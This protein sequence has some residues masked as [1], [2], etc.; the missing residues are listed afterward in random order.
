MF[1][2]LYFSFISA[3]ASTAAPK[4]LMDMLRDGRVKAASS[5]VNR[6]TEAC[7]DNSS[8]PFLVQLQSDMQLA[9]NLELDAEDTYRQSQKL[10]RGCKRDLRIASS[11]NTGWL[12]FHRHRFGT[13]MSCFMRVVEEPDV[14]PRRRVES[15]FGVLCVL[16]ELG[17]LREAVG[18]LDEIET[19][20]V[21]SLGQS[22]E[23]GDWH[24]LIDTLRV[25]LATQ[26]ELRS[27]AQ[28][29]DHVYWQ[30]VF[31]NEPGLLAPAENGHARRVASLAAGVRSPL[32][33]GRIEYLD[34]LRRLA[35]GERGAIEGL[36]VH[37]LWA[38]SNGLVAYQ[39]ALRT[40]ISL[41]SLAGSA[42]QMSE[43]ILAPLAGESRAA[44]GH[45]HLEYLYCMS[46][47]RQMQGRTHDSMQIY[48]RYALAAM[49][50]LR[51]ASRAMMPFT[52]RKCRQP[53]VFD[54]DVAARLP[55]RYRRAYRYLLDNLD[56]SDLSVRDVAAEIG[57]TERALQNAF[58]NSLGASPSE[59]IRQQR[60]ERI[61]AVLQG[62]GAPS[63]QA[64]LEVA[65]RWGVS[66]RSTLVN[67]Y[68][69]QFN[70]AP[71]ETL[72]R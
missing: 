4:E 30:S 67:G 46:K 58:K 5:H 62:D 2:T 68:R 49:Q 37:L 23:A 31:A 21:G 55:A 25:D 48:S 35:A 34:N 47:T 17:H 3:L 11:R 54:D 38:A 8:L 63:E 70:E 29:G 19:E 16:F 45:R 64:V 61:H 66:N 69:R 6:F 39:R 12:A 13:A 71:S 22:D 56:R 1:T 32:L 50:C 36:N 28:L 42:A 33:R 41:A 15:L 43:A 51:D 24:E 10:M 57:V 40:E 60:M 20:I 27:N 26:R 18:V 59:I 65:N 53:H 44:Q 72:K 52:Q 7:D 9:L 14:D